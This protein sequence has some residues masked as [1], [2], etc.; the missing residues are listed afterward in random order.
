M[1]FY[2]PIISYDASALNRL[3]DDFDSSIL[4]TIL[5]RNFYSRITST[6]YEEIT[7]NLKTQRRERLLNVVAPLARSGECVQPPHEI[8]FMLLRAS[9]KG[10]R[11]WR[12]LDIRFYNMEDA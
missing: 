2:R 10:N 4:Q 12:S 5:T 11:N 1:S 3:L 9:N 8:V 6:N 7:A